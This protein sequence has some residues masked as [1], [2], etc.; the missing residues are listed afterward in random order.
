MALLEDLVSTRQRLERLLA[1]QGQAAEASKLAEIREALAEKKSE[2]ERALQSLELLRGSG[3]IVADI[4]LSPVS[5]RITDIASKFDHEPNSGTVRRGS[6]WP[7]L[8]QSLASAVADLTAQ[9]D[10]SWSDYLTTLFAGLPPEQQE[11]RV[12]KTPA[13]IKALRLYK[14]RY[15]KFAAL[16][17]SPPTSKDALERL[18]VSSKELEGVKFQ[19]DVPAEI[20]RFF[21]STVTS[22]GFSLA[23]LSQDTLKWLKDND[24]LSQYIVRQ[25]L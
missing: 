19:L 17:A 22:A 12:A 6:R 24:M 14:E 3:V 16:K 8:L 25:R 18:K 10:Q 13:N 20:S 7:Q 11:G 5:G 1:M 23:D 9:R 15:A 2:M 4:D 21:E